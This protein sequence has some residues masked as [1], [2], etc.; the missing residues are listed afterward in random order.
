MLEDCLLENDSMSV[1]KTCSWAVASGTC[2]ILENDEKSI[3]VLEQIVRADVKKRTVIRINV[4]TLTV[5]QF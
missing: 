4:L 5:R 2:E 3:N 1:T